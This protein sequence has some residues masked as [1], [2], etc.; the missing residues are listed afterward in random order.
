MLALC[1]TACGSSGEKAL[2]PANIGIKFEH[3]ANA[4]NQLDSKFKI[5]ESLDNQYSQENHDLKLE[6]FFTKTTH[7]KCVINQSDHFIQLISVVNKVDKNQNL[8]QIKL[9]MDG[10]L[11]VF[12]VTQSL[13]QNLNP[14]DIEPVVLNAFAKAKQYP[15]VLQRETYY[16]ASY[17]LKFDSVLN[18]Y[19]FSVNPI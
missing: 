2:Q 10:P 12:M 16:K 19:L 11:L 3:F 5:P 13:N 17:S 15:D 4:F 9:T 6:Y 7:L 1:M 18:A 8:N 14:E